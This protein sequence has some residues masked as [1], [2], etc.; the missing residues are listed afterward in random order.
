MLSFLSKRLAYYAV[1]LLAA[2]CLSYLLA[3]SALSPRA[4]FQAR[5]PPPPAA[6]VEAQLTGL[7]L[8][9]HQPMVE[10]LTAW[11]A[12]VLHGDLGRT[13][14]DTSVNAEFGRRIGVSLRLLIAGTVVGTVLGVLV[15]VYS[16]VRQYQISDRFL[17][18]WS[19]LVLSMP[20]FLIALLLKIGALKVNE[21]AGTDVIR[22]TGEASPER[23]GGFAA[24]LGDHAVHLLLPTL[25]IA[26]T[27]IATYSRY[28]RNAMLDV[29]HSDHLRTARAKGLTRRQALLRH[30]LRTALIPMSTFLSFG[31]LGILTGAT[32]TEKIFGWHGMGEWF[33]DSINSNDV[34]SVVAVNI[35]AAVTVLAAGFLADVLHGL[36]DPR[37]RHG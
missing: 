16:A 37:V 7:G 33:I 18:L 12:G 23:H 1:L 26:F 13:I 14:A 21:A 11:A 8:N 19:F 10:R 22:F 5:L 31:I 32:F 36:L 34:N 6:Q 3:A 25:G 30:G 2:T 27:A 24:T 20:T 29:L 4:S 35:F 17:T 15:G 28:Q 9:D